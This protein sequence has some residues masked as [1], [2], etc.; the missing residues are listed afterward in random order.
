MK[1]VGFPILSLFI[2]LFVLFLCGSLWESLAPKSTF[3]LK[4]NSELYSQDIA[5]AKEKLK[6]IGIECD[7]AKVEIYDE[8]IFILSQSYSGS[9]DS[10]KVVL[11]KT[12]KM[13]FQRLRL[14]LFKSIGDSCSTRGKEVN[15]QSDKLRNIESYSS[16]KLALLRK[17]GFK[18]TCY[19]NWI[20]NICHSSVYDGSPLNEGESVI[21]YDQIST[22]FDKM[23]DIEDSYNALNNSPLDFQKNFKE[24]YSYQFQGSFSNF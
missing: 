13:D 2:S 5:F 12:D 1:K 22:D 10:K 6:W 7:D 20:G 11:V 3:W 17:N 24:F 18:T 4:D 23:V 19:K 8:P 16:E 9:V 21:T 14:L 15:I